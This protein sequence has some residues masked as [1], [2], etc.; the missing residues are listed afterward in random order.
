M[1]ESFLGLFTMLVSELM[2]NDFCFSSS[3]SVICEP[4]LPAEFIDTLL[5]LLSYYLLEV[6]S[7][8]K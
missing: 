1:K 6:L 8:S 7:Y 2:C 5:V 4:R 3:I